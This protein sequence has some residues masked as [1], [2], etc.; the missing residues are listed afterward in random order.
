MA[1]IG[2]GA[3]SEDADTLLR[4]MARA[5][6]HRGPDGE[7]LF[8]DGPMGLAFRRLALVG[9]TDGDQPLFSED[10]SVVLI[11]NGEVYN[12][13]ELEAVGRFRMRTKSDCEVLAHLYARDGLRF[14]DGVVGMYA[15]VLWDRRHGRLVLARD[16]FGIKPLY[17]TRIGNRVL[18]AS[19]IKGLFQHPECPRTL[20]W[21]GA[22]GDQ[23]MTA[24]PY[25]CHDPIN[26]WFEGIETVPAGTIVSIDLMTG[27]TEQHVYWR[28]P[29]F[30]GAADVSD[31][32]LVSAYRELLS[33]SVSDCVSADA[34]LGLFLSG[35]VDSAAVAAFARE[36]T[37]IHT[38]SIVSGSTLANGDAEF[39]DRTARL[40]GLPNYQLLF[41]VDRFPTT[42]EWKRLLWLLETPL[43]GPEQFYKYELY[44][45][46]KHV[47][48]E[49]RGMLLGQGSDEFN[50][51]YSDVISEGTDWPT[52]EADLTHMARA[53][54]LSGRPALAGWWTS[55][56]VPL[57]D[58]CLLRRGHRDLLDDPY[59]AYVAWKYRDIQQYNCWH[60][61]RTAAGNGIEARVPFLDHRIIELLATIPRERRARLL[62]NKRI[63]RDAVRDV[64]PAEIA[65]RPKVPF[66]YGEGEGFTHRAFVSMLAQDGGALLEEA[67]EAP[68]AQG[69]LRPDGMR[70]MLHRLENEI[71]P[72][73]VDVTYLIRLVNLGLLDQMTR[74]L[75]PV[76]LE[77]RRHEVRPAWPI[78]RWDRDAEAL[79]RRL[80]RVPEPEP[81]G[82]V[83]FPE[84]VVLVHSPSEPRVLYIAVDGEFEY[85]IDASHDPDWASFLR[86]VDGRRT[87][88]EILA[89]I[90]VRYESVAQTLWKAL[91]ACVLVHAKGGD[92]M[93][94]EVI[95]R[96]R[97]DTRARKFRGRLLVAG[98]DETAVELSESAMFIFRCIDGVRTAS[99]IGKLL[100]DEY[101]IPHQV[102]TAD[103]AELLA[104]LADNGIIELTG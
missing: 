78:V 27:R 52:F 56:E 31:G 64:L 22:L 59:S 38:F 8:R 24:A 2:G 84:A 79:G 91:D 42:D 43:C 9:P 88:A 21:E 55:R 58:D 30:D 57:V 93:R 94:L 20:D 102:A 49:I 4:R 41:D 96:Q 36:A 6:G 11:V 66:Y 101:G 3:L 17:H 63:L 48:P 15:L 47:R 92:P 53:T 51:G 76:P 77:A 45:Y 40:L 87:V 23:S 90:G 19:E 37:T 16:R 89:T 35:G 54:A 28:L 29:D 26:T 81:D 104:E 10:E 61:D 95:P 44:R 74:D 13:R 82:V 39:G 62:W 7:Q 73:D 100:A 70:A 103:T 18:V 34:E 12:H 83:A 60:E 1:L 33:A 14:L 99:D 75:P 32:E 25:L 65:D 67:V 98:P 85:V 72:A 68:G 46:A 97:M 5:V 86:N 80:H 71:E 69:F 50:G